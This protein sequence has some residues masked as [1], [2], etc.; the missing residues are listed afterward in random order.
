M[1]GAI[2]ASFVTGYADTYCLSLS[3]FF[4]F[5]LLYPE[6]EVM[7]FFVIPIKV[8]YLGMFAA[9]IWVLGFI[10]SSTWGKVND[11]LCMLGFILFFGPQMGRQ[12][13]AWWRREKWKRRNRR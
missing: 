12:L 7:L 5:A 11:L 1:L 8:K 3:L 4:A 6:I 2:V 9:A 13:R 10:F